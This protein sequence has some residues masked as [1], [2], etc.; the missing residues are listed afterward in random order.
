MNTVTHFGLIWRRKG[1]L[2]V[3]EAWFMEDGKVQDLPGAITIPFNLWP[4]HKTI[5]DN[6]SLLMEKS[7]LI[8]DGSLTD[9]E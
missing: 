1:R 3:G 7:G 5:L 2:M 6:L 4:E 8:D 9:E